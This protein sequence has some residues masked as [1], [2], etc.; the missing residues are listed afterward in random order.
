MISLRTKNDQ[1]A[2]VFAI[3]AVAILL[4]VLGCVLFLKAPTAADVGQGRIRSEH[5][6][7]DAAK[8]ARKKVV[9]LEAKIKPLVWSGAPEQVGPEALAQVTGLAK[10]NHLKL[11]AFRP[12]KALPV[13]PLT[14]T[15]F[16]ISIDGS[17]L[18]AMKFIQQLESDRTR[19][20]VSLIQ[21]SSADAW[22]DHVSGTVSVV[23]YVAS[24]P[25]GGVNAKS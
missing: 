20:A 22:S 2:A 9:A 21:L 13:D 25:K 15:P 24:A 7:E 3:L 1:L 4:G 18:D 11:V 14:Q 6:L 17:F 10:A 12:Q 23:A 8:S 19:L 16:T 5:Q